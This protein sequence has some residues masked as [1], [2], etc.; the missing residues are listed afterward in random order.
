MP[1]KELLA[2]MEPE[3]IWLTTQAELI[4]VR[5]I[6]RARPTLELCVKS[7][8]NISSVVVIKFVARKYTTNEVKTTV[9][10][11]ESARKTKATSPTRERSSVVL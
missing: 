11:F 8:I 2:M 6:P 7:S 5:Y 9:A 3:I 4:T 10:F 1:L